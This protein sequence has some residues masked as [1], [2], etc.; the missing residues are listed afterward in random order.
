MFASSGEAGAEVVLELAGSDLEHALIDKAAAITN[1]RAIM[2]MFLCR[3][4]EFK[5]LHEVRGSAIGRLLAA[6]AY[7]T[8]RPAVQHGSP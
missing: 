5:T 6:A 8:T 3:G 7:E 1:L 4:G 2:R